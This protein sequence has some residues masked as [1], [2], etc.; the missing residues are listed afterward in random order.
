[1]RCPWTCQ[2]SVGNLGTP[3]LAWGK[4]QL[5]KSTFDGQGSKKVIAIVEGKIL[6]VNEDIDLFF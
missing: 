5:Q 6:N 3:K 2:E 4:V 1:M